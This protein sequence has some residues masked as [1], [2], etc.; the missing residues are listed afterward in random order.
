MLTISNE[1]GALWTCGFNP[2]NP[3][4]SDLSFGPVYEPLIFVNT[5]Q[6]AKQTP[7]L[8]TNA[9]WSDG[10][11]VITFTIRSG[12]KWSDGTPMTAAD[13][14]FTFNLLKKFPGLDIQAVWSVLSSVKQQGS[15]QVVMTFKTAAVPY[16]YYIADQVP[17]VPQHIWSKIANPVTYN[18]PDPIGTG[19]YTVHPCTPENITYLANNHYWQAGEPH[20]AKVDYPAFTSNDPANTYLATGQ[21]QWGSQYIPSIAAFYTSKSSSYHYWFPPVA[22]VSLFINL[23]NPVLKNVAVRQAMAYAI[24]RPKVSQIGE[25]GYEPPSNQTGVVTPTFSAWQDTAAS[26]ADGNYSYNPA[27]AEQILTKAGYKKNS[28]GIF[29]SPSGQPLSFQV[30]NEGGFSDWVAAM[31]VIQSDLKAVGIAITPVNLAG[32][33]Y[34]TRVYDGDFQLAYGSETGGPTPYYELRQ[35]LYSANS[36]KIGTAAAT[37]WERYSSPATDALINAYGATTSV[38]TQHS[39]VDQLE[40]VML[41]DVPVIPVTEEVDWF[42]YDTAAFSGWET[43]TDPF[44]QPAAYNSPDWGVTL[45][46]LTAAK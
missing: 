14:A 15:N 44:A 22:N 7:W 12:V 42:Q 30:L 24:D 37:N 40:Q 39:I 36:A 45:L 29:V 34:D 6:N 28:S 11:K 8:A 32:T 27:K 3:S 5:L 16:F 4:V 19:A 46:H 18:D 35:L 21:A 17:I 13:V 41:N 38:A 9:V 20:I 43:P 1:S 25:S 10:N 33:D 26:A 31:Q 2:F 23:T